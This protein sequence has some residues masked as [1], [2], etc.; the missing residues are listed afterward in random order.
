MPCFRSCINFLNWGK[1]TTKV[2]T[3]SPKVNFLY[4][5]LNKVETPS[6]SESWLVDY[7]E[8]INLF[9][10]L[11]LI[12]EICLLADFFAGGLCIASIWWKLFPEMHSKAHKQ[13]QYC[14]K[15]MA[16]LSTFLSFWK[17]IFENFGISKKMA[18]GTKI[19]PYLQC[20]FSF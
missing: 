9:I 4:L 14:Q 1:I 17:I 6:F 20:F 5:I 11:F 13:T 10:L 8:T 3:K 19:F 15:S 2:Q 12:F 16:Q 7:P 18:S